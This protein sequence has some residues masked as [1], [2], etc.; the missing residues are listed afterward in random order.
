VG[1]AARRREYRRRPRPLSAGE[2]GVHDGGKDVEAVPA[3]PGHTRRVSGPA[4][5]GGPEALDFWVGEWECTWAGGRG[6]NRIAKELDDHVVVER[7]ESF[8]PERW[9]GL[10]VSVHDERHGWRQTWVDSTGNYWAFHGGP[11]PEGFAFAVTEREDDRDVEKRM[12]FSDVDA[13]RL[14]W[15]WERSSDG[16]RTWDVLW[17]IDYRRRAPGTRAPGTARNR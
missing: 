13:D 8:E 14:T 17:T 16:G 5:S 6:A 4:P 12:V 10:S 3:R 15:R 1:G 7:F 2:H 9:S 11:H